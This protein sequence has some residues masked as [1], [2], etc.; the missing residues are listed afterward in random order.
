MRMLLIAHLDTAKANEAVAS[1]AM[2]GIVQEIMAAYQPE[3]AYFAPL[4][5][6][7]SC[8]MVFDLDDPARLPALNEPL[9]QKLGA[10]ISIQ[11]ALTPQ[12]VA[13][14]L[15]MVSG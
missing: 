7:R 9:L 4:S 14:G 5:G 1:G 15:A 3:T 12:D 13:R 10:E 8:I 2:P 6:R 11:P